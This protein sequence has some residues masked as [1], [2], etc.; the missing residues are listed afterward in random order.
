[1][2][3]VRRHLGLFSD[4]L[5]KHGGLGMPAHTHTL[6][7]AHIIYKHACTRRFLSKV[8]NDDTEGKIKSQV[9]KNKVARNKIYKK[10]TT[11]LCYLLPLETRIHSWELGNTS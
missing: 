2:A 4:L 5:Y 9:K 10:A 6:E 3:E 7:H 11:G 1:M 8:D